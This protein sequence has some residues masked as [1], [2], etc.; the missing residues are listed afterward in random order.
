MEIS[1]TADAKPSSDQGMSAYNHQLY[2]I[3]MQQ[4]PDFEK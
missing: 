2:D 4:E 1:T 3:T